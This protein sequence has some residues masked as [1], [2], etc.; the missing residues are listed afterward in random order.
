MAVNAGKVVLVHEDTVGDHGMGNTVIIEHQL[1]VADNKIYSLYA[2]LASIEDGIAVEGLVAKGA[3]LGKMGASGNGDS[4]FWVNEGVGVHLH[5]EL[6][7]QPLMS[8]PSGNHWL[9]TPTNPDD[10]GY[11]DPNLYIGLKTALDVFHSSTKKLRF[12]QPTRTPQKPNCLYASDNCSKKGFFHTGIDYRKA[13]DTSFDEQFNES[14]INNWSQDSGDWT[15]TGGLYFVRPN[16][17]TR[18]INSVSTYNSTFT[19]FV[20][21]V[22]M[23]KVGGTWK[24]ANK[25]IIRAGGEHDSIGNFFNA[26]AF[27]YTKDG[28]FAVA[29][30]VNGAPGLLRGWKRSPAIKQGNEWNLL[31]VVAQGSQLSFFIN[32]KKVWSGQ[33]TNMTSGLVGFSVFERKK[34]SFQIDWATLEPIAP[35]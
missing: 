30:Y 1:P 8:D 7:D 25:V 9:F 21:T 29:R 26:Y 17:T 20:F 14:A 10:F 27:Q 31:K 2:H 12:G 23:R 32:G 35:N 34:S 6:K 18:S 13:S 33:D 3:V 16:G 22:R 15:R 11:S 19:D 24:G 4:C 28:Y 5:F